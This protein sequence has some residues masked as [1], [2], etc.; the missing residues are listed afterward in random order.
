[1]SENKAETIEEQQEDERAAELLESIAAAADGGESFTVGIW[2]AST[3]SLLLSDA[4][5]RQ[6]IQQLHAAKN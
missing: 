3:L 4:K 1:M 2:E 5:Y 6:R